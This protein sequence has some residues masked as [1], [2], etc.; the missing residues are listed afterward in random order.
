MLLPFAPVIQFVP[1][2]PFKFLHETWTGLKRYALKLLAELVDT[3]HCPLRATLST[4]AMANNVKIISRVTATIF[5]TDLIGSRDPWSILSHS[6]ISGVMSVLPNKD[7]SVKA[8]LIIQCSVVF[9]YPWHCFV[10]QL[11]LTASY[12]EPTQLSICLISPSVH[13]FVK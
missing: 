10:T 7:E 9:H 6:K 1:Q 8:G 5:A 11:Q 4:L 13:D 2:W 12:E 3:V